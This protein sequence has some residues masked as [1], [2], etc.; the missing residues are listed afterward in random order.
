MP[1]LI[2][3]EKFPAEPIVFVPHRLRILLPMVYSDTYGFEVIFP[4]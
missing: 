2:Q 4:I 1:K 3:Y